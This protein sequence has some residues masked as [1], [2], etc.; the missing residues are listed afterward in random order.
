MPPL[1]SIVAEPHDDCEHLPARPRLT[2]GDRDR[3][4]GDRPEELVGRRHFLLVFGAFEGIIR[5]LWVIRA[6]E[7]EPA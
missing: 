6:G 4:P 5:R 1:D 7:S 2:V 3:S